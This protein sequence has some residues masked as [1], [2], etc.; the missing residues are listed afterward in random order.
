M[1]RYLLIAF[2]IIAAVLGWIL[3]RDNVKPITI[4]TPKISEPANETPT[5]STTPEAEKPDASEPEPETEPEAGD[6]LAAA[7]LKEP[8][9]LI[10][11]KVPFTVQAPAGEWDDQRQQDGCEEASALMAMRW[12]QGKG[13]TTSESRREILAISDYEQAEYGEYRDVSVEDVRDWIFK[14]YFKYDKV[15]VRTNVTVKSL[16]AELQAGRVIVAPMHGQKLHNPYFSGEGPERHMLVIRG[17]DPAKKEFIT[18]DP[19]TK[20]GEGYRYKESVIMDALLAYPT[21][22]HEPVSGEPKS[23]VVV[24]K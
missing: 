10:D 9:T 11:T 18:N 21:G 1:R 22:Y 23:V 24:G 7:T 5:A 2:I 20:R 4:D 15:A 3:Y 14:D 13:L 16:I 6:T 8:V 19:G 12:A 17:Y